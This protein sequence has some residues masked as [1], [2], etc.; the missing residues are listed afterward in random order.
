ARDEE[1]HL[2]KT[3]ESV[4]AQT[5]HPVEWW[6]VNDGSTDRTGEIIE[7]YS[8][9]Y[10]W[11][12][13]VHRS[14]RGFR[15]AGGGVVEAFNDGYA[16]IASREWDFIVKFD[17]DLSFGPDYFQKCFEYFGREPDL[18]IGGGE[19]YHVLDGREYLE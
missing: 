7:E 16:S 14:N 10:P 19:I 11:I 17:G 12:H 15:K 9:R 13:A 2:E 6:I 18:G 4:A 3:I 8:A 5:I 1:A